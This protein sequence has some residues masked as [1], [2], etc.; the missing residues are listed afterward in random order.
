M[1]RQLSVLEQYIGSYDRYEV[2]FQRSLDA[3]WEAYG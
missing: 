1:V 2:L 3:A